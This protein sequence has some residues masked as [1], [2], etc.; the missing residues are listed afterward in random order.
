MTN[1]DRTKTAQG[2]EEFI[3]GKRAELKRVDAQIANLRSCIAYAKEI[4]LDT[5]RSGA[6]YTMREHQ[7]VRNMVMADLNTLTAITI[8]A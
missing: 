5:V 6:G 7:R 2:L 8:P 1:A 4:R 3:A